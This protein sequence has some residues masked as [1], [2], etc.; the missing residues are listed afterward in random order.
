MALKKKKN[1][2]ITTDLSFDVFSISRSILKWQIKTFVQQTLTLV[3]IEL[4]LVLYSFYFYFFSGLD[5]W[6]SQNALNFF[7]S[8]SP[9][10]GSRGESLHFPAQPVCMTPCWKRLR[11]EAES[12]SVQLW[13]SYSQITNFQNLLLMQLPWNTVKF[14]INYSLTIIGSNLFSMITDF[15]CLSHFTI[16]R[17]LL[18]IFITMIYQHDV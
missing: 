4:C 11:Y 16:F 12:W 13:K 17:N 9:T 2:H 18:W 10:I 6:W 8:N 15:V 1:H 7:K 3:W 5:L 14:N